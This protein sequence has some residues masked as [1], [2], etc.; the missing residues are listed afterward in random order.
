[1]YDDNGNHWKVILFNDMRCSIGHYGKNDAKY[2]TYT[3][4]QG[5]PILTFN[6]PP[7]IAFPDG[8]KRIHEAYI[9]DDSYFYYGGA[10][11]GDPEMRLS[12]TE[13]D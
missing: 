1:M 4:E 13:V 9:D 3:V 12:L 6:N 2:G 7:Y 5:T 10:D 11:Y 8:K